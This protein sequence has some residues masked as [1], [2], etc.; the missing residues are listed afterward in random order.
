VAEGEGPGL[1]AALRATNPLKGNPYPSLGLAFGEGQRPATCGDADHRKRHQ[2]VGVQAGL[3]Q[4]LG[5]GL[6]LA[7]SAARFVSL[8]GDAVAVAVESGRV[9]GVPR[10]M[11]VRPTSAQLAWKASDSTKTGAEVAGTLVVIRTARLSAVSAAVLVV[12]GATV[13]VVVL[14]SVVVVP[15][16]GVSTANVSGSDTQSAVAASVVGDTSMVV[17]VVTA[18]SQTVFSAT[19]VVVVV[20]AS[21]DA[22]LIAIAMQER[23][24]STQPDC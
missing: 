4:R 1:A 20:C 24:L 16:S 17:E 13:V 7:P 3:G 9:R 10:G 22:E 6:G 8:T 19:V 14:A 15:P 2:H 21:A 23:S 12:V 18:S 11:L 5:P